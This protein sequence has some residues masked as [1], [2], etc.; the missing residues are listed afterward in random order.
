MK[1]KKTPYSKRNIYK[2]YDDD[3]NLVAE[4]KA[5]RDG[6]DEGVISML[7]KM[8]DH[9]VYVNYKENRHPE[10]YQP[11]YDEWRK[12][13]IEKFKEE[14]GY[15]PN[16]DEIPGQRRQME[17]IDA[18]EDFD[19]EENLGDNSRLSQELSYLM[20]DDA[21]TAIERAREIVSEMPEQWQKVYQL[22][23][24]EGKLK[25]H[26]ASELSVSNARVTRIMK[27]ITLMLRADMSLKKFFR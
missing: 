26:A 14:Y 2:H 4:Y 10:W 24:I 15:A 7:H 11:I 8:D 21:M 1:Y 19:G 27:D 9:E 17:F 20:E 3:G 25:S 23:F 22:V 12:D 16:K 6:I 18:Q 13:Y 5:D